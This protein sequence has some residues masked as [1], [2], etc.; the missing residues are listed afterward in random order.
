M[1]GGTF[2]G[3][4][5]EFVWCYGYRGDDEADGDADG[6]ARVRCDIPGVEVSAIFAN[7]IGDS[8]THY[9]LRCYRDEGR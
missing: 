7:Q 8:L 2:G 5:Y 1:R 6:C 9:A 3:V 4:G